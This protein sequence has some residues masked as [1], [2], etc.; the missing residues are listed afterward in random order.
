VKR[1]GWNRCASRNLG[2]GRFAPP[3]DPLAGRARDATPE[4][5]WM[6]DLDGDGRAELVT[7]EEMSRQDASMR[8]E[9]DEARE[10]HARYRVHALGADLVW[11]PEPKRT[12]ELVG[13]IFGGGTEELGIPEDRRLDGDRRVD[14]VGL[15]L[16]FSMVQMLAS[17][18]RSSPSASTSAYCQTPD[19]LFS[20]DSR[21]RI[22]AAVHAPARTRVRVGQ[23]SSFAGDFDGDGAPDFVL[24]RGREV[25]VLGAAGCRSPSRRGEASSLPQSRRTS[26]R[27]RARP[28]RRRAAILAVTNPPAKARSAARDARSL[29]RRRAASMNLS[30]AAARS[31]SLGSGFGAAG[32]RRTELARRRNPQVDLGG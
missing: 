1:P 2:G 17:S 12:F 32:R 25:T 10:P 8:E 30:R 24:G 3:I 9:L 22:W 18:A 13:H 4:V 23:L 6:G 15:K 21:T 7:Q 14:P 11:R 31:R 29:S 20:V 16:D 5:V 28:R 27:A 26:P 19:G